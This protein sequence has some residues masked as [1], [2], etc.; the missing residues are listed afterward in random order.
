MSEPETQEQ[1]DRRFREIDVM[2]KEYGDAVA[3]YAAWMAAWRARQ[4]KGFRAK[5]RST[6]GKA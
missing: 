5:R 6:E 1:I 4:A 2:L 3:A